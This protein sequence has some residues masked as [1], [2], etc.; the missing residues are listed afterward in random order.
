M[1]DRYARISLISDRSPACRLD[2]AS[3][4]AKA[5]PKNCGVG[6]GFFADLPIRSSP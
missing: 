3:K 4:K 2:L 5:K 6:F 1:Q